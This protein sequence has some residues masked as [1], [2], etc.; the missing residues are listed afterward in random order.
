MG[1][2]CS[3]APGDDAAT[4]APVRCIR[5]EVGVGIHLCLPRYRDATRRTALKVAANE[6]FA[7]AHRTVGADVRARTTA[8]D[9]NLLSQELDA[10]AGGA[11]CRAVGLDCAGQVCRTLR[12]G[13]KN[14]ASVP[15]DKTV[16]ADQAALVE[17]RL[18]ELLGRPGGEDN[19]AAVGEDRPAVVDQALQRGPVDADHGQ[20]V[21]L[22]IEGDFVA[23]GHDGRTA[24]RGD[25]SLIF[26]D[27]AEQ[28]NGTAGGHRDLSLVA[29][30]GIG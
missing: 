3:F 20:A 23:A 13:V 25:G 1:G 6:D 21:T 5:A 30:F 29:N 12:T 18:I 4:F 10:A 8:A 22:E 16:S 24:G 9:E 2:S 19:P 17:H 14:D 11:C 28:G 7:A 26:D 27:G 15:F